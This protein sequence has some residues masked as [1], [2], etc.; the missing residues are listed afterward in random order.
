MSTKVSTS[1]EVSIDNR[2]GTQ[3]LTRSQREVRVLGS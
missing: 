1:E 3:L 2:V